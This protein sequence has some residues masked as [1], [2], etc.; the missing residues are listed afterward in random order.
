MHL[1]VIFTIKLLIDGSDG[2]GLSEQNVTVPN[3]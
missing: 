1:P 3:N 2:I